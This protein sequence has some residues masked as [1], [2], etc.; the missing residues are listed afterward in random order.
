LQH[1]VSILWSEICTSQV[2][3]IIP[4]KKCRHIV[5]KAVIEGMSEKDIASSLCISQQ[6]VNKWKRK[7]MEIIRCHLRHSQ[8]H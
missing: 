8:K 1:N 7:G 3:N 5:K 6:G 2:I 4:S